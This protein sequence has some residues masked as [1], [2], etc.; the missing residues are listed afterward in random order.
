MAY[1]LDRLPPQPVLDGL[2][3]FNRLT[4]K[5]VKA[6]ISFDET[7]PTYDPNYRP[8]PDYLHGYD[9]YSIRDFMEEFS[10]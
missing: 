6:P 3:R 2:E 1:W 5:M 9:S 8:N 10:S 4:F 7:L